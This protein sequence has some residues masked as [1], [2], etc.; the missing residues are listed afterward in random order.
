MLLHWHHSMKLPGPSSTRSYYIAQRVCLP[1]GNSSNSICSPTMNAL[2]QQ[3]PNNPLAGGDTPTPD[4]AEAIS[5]GSLPL[6]KML[7]HGR[8]GVPMEVM[9]LML[10]Q[11][12][13]E[14]TVRSV[15]F[16]CFLALYRRVHAKSRGR[17]C[18]GR[19]YIL[20]RLNL[21][22]VASKWYRC[23]C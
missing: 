9:G 3:L 18:D 13:D 2:L 4:T 15:H 14:Y 5:I 10:G 21:F 11:F 19:C 12:V 7:K 1:S 8:A 17:F 20:K 22:C 23:F 6:L 16:I